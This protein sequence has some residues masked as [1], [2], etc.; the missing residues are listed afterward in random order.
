[1][2]EP[3]PTPRSN[4]DFWVGNWAVHLRDT[5]EL[6]GHNRIERIQ[7]GPVLLENYP[8]V[9]G[10]F[11][12]TSLSGYDH[13]AGRWHQCWMDMTGLV[14]DLYGNLVDGAMVMSGVVEQGKTER[15]SWTPDLDGSVRQRWQQSSDNGATWAAVFDGMYRRT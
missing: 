7:L 10:R 11:S 3:P 4:F 6:I 5:N 8:T 12:G 13:I 1:M 2:T 14:L 15:I 9:N